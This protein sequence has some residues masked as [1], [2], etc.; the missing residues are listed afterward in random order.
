MELTAIDFVAIQP[1]IAQLGVKPAMVTAL[2]IYLT[3][4]AQEHVGRLLE[5]PNVPL[6][7][8]AHSQYFL[9]SQSS[10]LVTDTH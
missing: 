8:A 6:V 10:A 9:P 1:L 4:M 2:P 7:N 5:T 3:V